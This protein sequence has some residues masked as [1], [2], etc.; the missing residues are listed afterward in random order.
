MNNMTEMKLFTTLFFT[1]LKYFN[2]ISFIK[3]Y[4]NGFLFSH[5][6]KE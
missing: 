6:H 4:I 2:N 5:L 3:L 1:Q